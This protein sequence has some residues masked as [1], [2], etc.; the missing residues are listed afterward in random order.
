M[1]ALLFIISGLFCFGLHAGPG[2]NSDRDSAS[3]ARAA[4]PIE[5]MVLG[6]PLVADPR[7]D[8][9]KGA[10]EWSSLEKQLE[11]VAAM[12]VTTVSVDVWWG[13]VHKKR[14]STEDCFAWE[15]YDYLFDL[16]IRKGLKIA[17]I[18]SA[19]TYGLNVN[20]SGTGIPLPDFIITIMKEK[21]WG[22]KSELGNWNFE[23]VAPWVV[24]HL[25]PDLRAYWSAFRKQYASRA[26]HFSKV[27]V[28]MGPAG[29]LVYP[30]YHSHDRANDPAGEASEARFPGRGLL[31][32]C[33][34]QAITAFQKWLKNKY[35]TIGALNSVWG[36]AY[37]KFTEIEI[38]TAHSEVNEFFAGYGQ[39]SAMGQ[40]FFDFLHG[41][42]MAAGLAIGNAAADELHV[43][44]GGMEQMRLAAKTG[45][46]HWQF[47]DRI[48]LLTAGLVSS[49]GAYRNGDPSPLSWQPP[50]WSVEEGA[51]LEAIFTEFLVPLRDRSASRKKGEWVSI[52]TCA[53]MQSCEAACLDIRSERFGRCA[54]CR[55][56]NYPGAQARSG[57]Q[58]L[59]RAVMQLAEKYNFRV[60]L[61]N[62]LEGNVRNRDALTLI[63]TQLDEWKHIFGVSL[64]RL[65]TVAQSPEAEA[66][67]QSI[68]GKL[69]RQLPCSDH[70]VMIGRQQAK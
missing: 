15:Y 45:G 3:P 65:V 44:G 56:A 1:K 17:P 41:S 37:R 70:I 68:A 35:K 67:Y 51:G 7:V 49:R 33:S 26:A 8:G 21:G 60:F 63:S 28:G 46:V 20:D 2:E 43:D 13:L 12:G 16:I 57:A 6:P 62:A 19:H 50:G 40:D 31:Q 64:L 48:P 10:A 52:F 9:W 53:E 18:L 29:E 14:G 59:L 47:H 38:L 66:F 25:L 30:A 23:A 36:R 69:D 61:E 5:L 11:K 42:L 4:E 22:Y 27:I 54:T 58:Q 55:H 24:P 34:P 39:Y 32:H